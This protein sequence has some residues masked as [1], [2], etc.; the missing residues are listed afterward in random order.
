MAATGVFLKLLGSNYHGA[1]GRCAVTVAIT[2]LQTPRYLRGCS[3]DGPG[4]GEEVLS[5]PHGG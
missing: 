2:D 5:L 3:Q 4:S 1:N